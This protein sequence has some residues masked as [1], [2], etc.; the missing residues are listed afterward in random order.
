MAIRGS[1]DASKVRA[2]RPL[3]IRPMIPVAP[4]R[5]RLGSGSRPRAASIAIVSVGF[6]LELSDAGSGIVG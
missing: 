5:R 4:Q 1:F 6:T 2:I 3:W